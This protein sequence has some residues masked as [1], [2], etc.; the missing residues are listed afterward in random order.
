MKNALILIS[1]IG[2]YL[3]CSFDSGNVDK[4][5]EERS[6]IPVDDSTKIY[7]T[8]AEW[9]KILSAEVYNITREKGTERAFTG[10]YWDYKKK[11]TYNCVCCNLPLFKSTTKFDSGTGWP[12]FYD[13]MSDNV[14][15]ATD[16]SHGMLRSEVLCKR[17][18]AHLGHVFD[19]GP[20]PTGLRYCINSAAL[21]FIAD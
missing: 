11:G 1:L 10:K 8:R 18:D 12:S 2:L 20:D 9:K 13:K 4:H 6:A 19:D 15:Q 5:V 14:R 17:C 3:S 7:K 21:K 16:E